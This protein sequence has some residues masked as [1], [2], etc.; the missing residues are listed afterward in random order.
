MSPHPADQPPSSALPEQKKRPASELRDP[1]LEG[2]L[3]AHACPAKRHDSKKTNLCAQLGIEAS[4]QGLGQSRRQT[5]GPYRREQV[6]C[7]LGRRR[8]EQVPVDIV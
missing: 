1:S 7:W 2:L 6:R 5:G 3:E 4:Q 8:T